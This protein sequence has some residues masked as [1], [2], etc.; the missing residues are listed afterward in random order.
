MKPLSPL[1]E[2]VSAYAN[3]WKRCGVTD[4]DIARRAYIAKS[5]FSQIRNGIAK[6]PG[7]W[8]ARLLADSLGV[9]LDELM[10]DSPTIREN[11]ANAI[12][13]RE[14]GQILSGAVD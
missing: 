11:V 6:N 5:Q 4:A 3:A 1:S 8:T 9:T 2:N 14:R 13:K 10:T 12:F 7:V